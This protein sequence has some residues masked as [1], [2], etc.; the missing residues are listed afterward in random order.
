METGAELW[1]ISSQT[2]AISSLAFLPDGKG[3]AGV[4]GTIKVWDVSTG[5][6]MPD[7]V[8]PPDIDGP[9]AS[10][11][12]GKFLAAQDSDNAAISV[13]IGDRSSYPQTRW[14]DGFPYRSEVL[15]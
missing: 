14:K 2:D 9:L 15:S 7:Q 11:S 4:D 13:G 10:S 8:K 1:T 5:A 12:D 3:F 6:E